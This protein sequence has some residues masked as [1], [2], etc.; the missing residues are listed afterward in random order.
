MWTKHGW[1][2]FLY[3]ILLSKISQI[4]LILKKI[5]FYETF[6]QDEWEGGG[7]EIMGGDDASVIGGLQ[8]MR[9]R[10]EMIYNQ[11][12]KAIRNIL[13]GFKNYAKR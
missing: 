2:E 1:L 13:R 8:L 6:V 5:N 4:S 3:S 9:G 7:W 12:E 11:P 10:K